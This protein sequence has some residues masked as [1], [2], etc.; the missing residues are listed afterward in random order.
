MNAVTLIRIDLG[1][2]SF[3]V[4][5]QDAASLSLDRNAV[6]LTCSTI[7]SI[8]G[9]R[10]KVM[11]PSCLKSGQWFCSRLTTVQSMLLVVYRDPTRP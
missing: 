1:K 4:H 11:L 8:Y 10:Q 6:P 2:H 3:H 5:G 7:N 9:C